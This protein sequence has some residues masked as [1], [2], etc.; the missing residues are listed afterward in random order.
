MLSVIRCNHFSCISITITTIIERMSF[1]SIIFKQKCYFLMHHHIGHHIAIHKIKL[2]AL[3]SSCSSS[4]VTRTSNYITVHNS[5]EQHVNI[6][7]ITF[8]NI[9]SIFHILLLS[10]GHQHSSITSS[11]LL[12]HK[13]LTVIMLS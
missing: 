4:V 10:P 11:S 7:I 6:I 2:L 5:H 8:I 9:I 12:S 1:L 13:N 3:S